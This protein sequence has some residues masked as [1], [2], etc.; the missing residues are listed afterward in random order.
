M[1]LILSLLVLSL[2]LPLALSAQ[3]VVVDGFPYGVGNSIDK[4]FFKPYYDDLKALVDTLNKYPLTKAV[5]TGRADGKPYADENDAK[6]PALALGRAHTLRNF[7]VDNF[8]I[9]TTRLFIQSSDV[10][11]LGNPYRY[12][13]VR[14]A[15]DLHYLNAKI[16]EVAARP[17]VEGGLAMSFLVLQHRQAAQRHRIRPGSATARRCYYLTLRRYPNRHRIYRMG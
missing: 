8:D 17:P 12:A 1:K 14:I 13:S 9:D 11:D 16:D 6:N 2:L 10:Y 4:D 5:I 7:L 3:E 15:W